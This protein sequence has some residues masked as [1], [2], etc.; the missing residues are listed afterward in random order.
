MH[1]CDP[2][3]KFI[4]FNDYFT[5][6][7]TR[8]T[9]Y[10]SAGK[11]ALQIGDERFNDLVNKVIATYADGPLSINPHDRKTQNQVDKFIGKGNTMSLSTLI[12]GDG[13]PLAV[14][15]CF[16]PGRGDDDTSKDVR[17]TFRQ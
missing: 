1:S 6:H 16:Y 11:T 7:S 14:L 10:A 4:V 2:Y 3:F 9:V 15:T 13:K 8:S 12:V 17:T 5:K